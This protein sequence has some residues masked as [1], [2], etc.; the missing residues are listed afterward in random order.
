ME[1]YHP[2][3]TTKL[4]PP[5]LGSRAI[6][7]EDLLASLHGARQCKLVLITAGTGYGK[8]TL[9]AQWR[10]KLIAQGASV[11]WL[12]LGPDDEAPEAFCASLRAV[13]LHA[14]RVPGRKR[15]GKRMR[16]PP[17]ISRRWPPCAKSS[18]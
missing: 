9:M 5:R 6:P 15:P 13:L 17:A 4:A 10:Q 7:R 3:P 8:T 16:W 11:A 12:T 1:R 18:T 2:A 14:R